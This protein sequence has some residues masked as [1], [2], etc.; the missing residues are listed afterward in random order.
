ARP[1]MRSNSSGITT[2]SAAAAIRDFTREVTVEGRGPLQRCV[3][4]GLCIRVG[5]SLLF[6]RCR[7]DDQAV[8]DHIIDKELGVPFGR[9]AR[10]PMLDQLAYRSLKVGLKIVR[11]V[12][13]DDSA[14]VCGHRTL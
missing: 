5:R 11:R 8:V 4:P 6:R 7:D 1:E 13:Q 14:E 3:R 9:T 2:S 10:N 12:G